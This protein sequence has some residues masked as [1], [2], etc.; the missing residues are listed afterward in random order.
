MS[1]V[2]LKFEV[3]CFRPP[4]ARLNVNLKYV[5]SKYR[6]YINNDLIVERSWVWNNN[7]FLKEDV[8]ITTDQD[9]EYMLELEPVVFIPEQ[10]VFTINDFNIV[11][12]RADSTKIND[13]Q[14]NFTLR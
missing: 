12:A 13:L 10:A 14:V 8:W 1:D 9:R 11:N 5:D 7:I 4:W 2:N 3:H 6:I